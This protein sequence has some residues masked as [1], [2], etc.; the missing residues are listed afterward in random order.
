M[1]RLNIQKAR[2]A[3]ATDA[4]IQQ[5]LASNPG[6][7]VSGISR[8][9][10]QPIQQQQ[11]DTLGRLADF[12][13][14]AGG[15]AGSFIPGAGTIVGGALGAGAGTLLKQLV[16]KEDVNIGEIGKEAAL[17]GAGGLAAKGVGAAFKGARALTG[18]GK[19]TEGISGRVASSLA[20]KSL[21]INPGQYS[22]LK[23]ITGTSPGRF[24]LKEGLEGKAPDVV[25]STIQPIQKSFT[26]LAEKQGV[27]VDP[28]T[29]FQKL[30]AEHSQ[31]SNTTGKLAQAKA[32]S[33]EDAI[34][35]F[36]D[37][38]GNKT[39]IPIKDINQ[40]AI[41]IGKLVKDF[42]TAGVERS[43]DR[44]LR[45]T[46]RTT[47]QEAVDKAGLTSSEGQTL[48]EL[49]K[50]LQGLY[51][52]ESVAKKQEGIGKGANIAGLTGLLGAG[53]LG[54]GGGLGGAALGFAGTKLSQ[55]PKVLA[56][57]ARN[58]DKMGQPGAVAPAAGIAGQ[59][60]G[61]TAA[62]G[63]PRVIADQVAPEQVQPEIPSQEASPITSE[64]SG[65]GA[66]SPVSDFAGDDVSKQKQVKQAFLTA[67]IANPKQA[68]TL[69]KIYDFGFGGEE[70][71]LSDT[72]IKNITDLQGAREDLKGLTQS[73]TQQ[74]LTGPIKGFRARNPYDIDAASLQAEID[75]V[76]QVVGKALEGGVLRKEDE[77]KYK[78]ILPVM[79]DTKEVALNKLEKLQEKLDSDIVRYSSSQRKYGKGRSLDN[80]SSLQE[81]SL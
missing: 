47:I 10:P 15:V 42:D 77:E 68:A 65:E 11:P 22:K 31:V 17:S 24:I 33:L 39:A 63:I 79:T 66:S 50:R 46:Y 64:F 12:L 69:Q 25:R 49:G 4:Q 62:Q 1:P 54:P 45:D 9:Q 8:P 73:I 44:V 41:S 37:K 80:A 52:L 21:R 6:L 34:M 13:P 35:S 7:S 30:I 29:I 28:M 3:G 51:E 81:F 23:D 14:L 38:Y 36:I 18:T 67:M 43:A 55:S 70:L 74:D 71:S 20:E 53:L 58:A 78:K 26:D 40:E 75:R 57:L 76:R 16:K 72:A 59:I 56:F 27:A 48:K 60:A 61:Q 32:K 2:E 19:A 5:Y